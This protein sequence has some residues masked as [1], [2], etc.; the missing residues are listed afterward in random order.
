MMYTTNDGYEFTREGG[1]RKGLATVAA[2]QPQESNAD[3][4]IEYDVIV[5]GAGYTGLSAIRDLT[6]GGKKVL[7]LEG[8]DRVGGRTMTVYEH[9][10][11]WELGGTWIHWFQPWIWTEVCRYGMDSKLKDSQEFYPESRQPTSIINGVRTTREW[12]DPLLRGLF[13][14]ISVRD[15]MAGTLAFGMEATPANWL[16]TESFKQLDKMSLQDR[17]DEL[18]MTDEEVG[19]L[20]AN[21]GMMA[22]GEPKDLA[23]SE[24]V[25]WWAASGSTSEGMALAMSKWKLADGQAS[26]ARA[27]FDDANITGNLSYAFSTAVTSIKQPEDGKVIVRTTSGK[28]YNA[29]K[30][31]CTIPLNVLKTIDFEPALD[32]IKVEAIQKGHNNMMHKVYAEVK[33]KQW[34]NWMG[35]AD[36]SPGLGMLIG[37]GFSTAGNSLLVS[38]VSNEHVVPGKEPEKAIAAIQAIEPEM[39]VLG[40]DWCDDPF[41]MGGWCFYA[42]EFQTKYIRKLQEPHGDV[43]FANTDWANLWRSFIDGA[44]EQGRSA[45]T[46]ILKH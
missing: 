6:K 8:R 3:A 33:G 13:Q 16:D 18:D 27:I 29:K 40:N 4:S 34:R 24:F 7:L 39:E 38:T 15:G 32:P 26:L 45:A 46:E 11:P 22:K 31:V 36:P 30:V 12:D 5:I 21:V 41:S 19:L 25:R 35:L 10:K 1:L 9:G 14:K 44:V 2:I 43:M 20:K 17:I 28:E 23:L 37:E 42:P